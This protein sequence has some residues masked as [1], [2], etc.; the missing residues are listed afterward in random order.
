MLAFF[1]LAIHKGCARTHVH[2]IRI[3][4]QVTIPTILLPFLV[5]IVQFFLANCTFHVVVEPPFFSKELYVVEITLFP[6]F[7]GGDFG[8]SVFYINIVDS[9]RDCISLSISLC[10]QDISARNYSQ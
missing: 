4:Q 3:L 8:F 6:F 7:R 1:E 2:Q 9:E 10:R 5:F